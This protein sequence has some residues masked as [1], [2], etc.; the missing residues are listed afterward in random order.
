MGWFRSNRGVTAE[1]AFLALIGHHVLLSVRL[2]LDGFSLSGF[3]DRSAGWI[4]AEGSFF[5]A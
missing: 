5:H 2:S 3:S 4:A 1:A